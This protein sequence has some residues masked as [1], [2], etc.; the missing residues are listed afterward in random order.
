MP[1]GIEAKARVTNVCMITLT[2]WI[3]GRKICAAS[4][5]PGWKSCFWR[6]PSDDAQQECRSKVKQTWNSETLLFLPFSFY[7]TCFC[8]YRVLFIDR[9]SKQDFRNLHNKNWEDKSGCERAAFE[10][11]ELVSYLQ[12]DSKLNCMI[13]TQIKPPRSVRTRRN[14]H[15]SVSWEPRAS[16][17][18]Y[19]YSYM[20]EAQLIRQLSLCLTKP[21]HSV[22]N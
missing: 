9:R 15:A 6:L 2:A 22:R 21:Q 12:F 20:S 17:H 11:L 7:R 4:L 5:T 1:S 16:F 14:F 13:F 10:Y 18:S 8:V 19:A 3:V